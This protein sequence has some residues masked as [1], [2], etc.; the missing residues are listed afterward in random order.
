M[1][2]MAHLGAVGWWMAGRSALTSAA[3]FGAWRLGFRACGLWGYRGTSLVRITNPH[4]TS[5][6]P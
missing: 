5:V 4:R 3:C 6:G 1:Y 2:Q